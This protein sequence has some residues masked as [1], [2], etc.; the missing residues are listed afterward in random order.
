M[1]FD[2]SDGD[3]PKKSWRERDRGANR[4]RHVNTAA[5]RE[6]ERFEKTTAY[7]NYKQKLERVFAGGELSQAMR[8]KLDPSGRGKEK[9]KKL[10]AIRE[11]EDS[12]SFA[13]AL[14]DYLKEFELPD[15]PYLL[16]RAL[17]HPKAEVQRRALIHLAA[18]RSDGKLPKPP[19]SLK[20]RLDSLQLN[21]DDGE[22]QDLARD[23]AKALGR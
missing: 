9:D 18:L 11:A 13:A 3:R 21:S 2:P 19:P 22:V 7:T 16:D 14:D 6:R 5:D 20:L 15:D 12:R 17:E 8:E 1:P 10:K 4:S 23:L